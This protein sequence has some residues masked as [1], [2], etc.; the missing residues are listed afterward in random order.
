MLCRL[1]CARFAIRWRIADALP[2]SPRHSH[3]R[4][5]LSRGGKP[6][7]KVWLGGSTP[8]EITSCQAAS[9]SKFSLF[10]LRKRYI[11]FKDAPNK[12]ASYIRVPQSR[13]KAARMRL[14]ARNFVMILR[15]GGA[16]DSLHISKVHPRKS[17][18]KIRSHLSARLLQ[19]QADEKRRECDCGREI[20]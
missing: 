5:R 9:R 17:A 15:G 2:S 12:G 7:V 4:R 8:N 11:I 20:L 10:R 16:A 18:Q 3:G 14:W 1:Q 19:L 13:R 6:P